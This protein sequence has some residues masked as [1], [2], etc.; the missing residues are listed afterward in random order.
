MKWSVVENIEGIGDF[1]RNERLLYPST[2]SRTTVFHRTFD[3]MKSV[4]EKE[5][6]IT[7]ILPSF[8]ICSNSYT[9]ISDRCSPFSVHDG[10]GPKWDT[11]W[12]IQETNKKYIRLVG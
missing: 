5:I 9:S 10:K 2:S 11:T 7:H 1:R 3:P 12:Y 4:W 6:I 8:V